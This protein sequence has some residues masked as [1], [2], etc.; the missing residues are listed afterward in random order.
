MPQS[1]R[2]ITGIDRPEELKQ[3]LDQWLELVT[4]RD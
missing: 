4:T 1:H 3:Q 2:I